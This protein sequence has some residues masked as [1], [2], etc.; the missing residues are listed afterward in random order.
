[1]YSKKPVLC[2]LHNHNTYYTSF[3]IIPVLLYLI[4][5]SHSYGVQDAMGFNTILLLLTVLL[6]PGDCH[7]VTPNSTAVAPA[8]TYSFAN[9]QAVVASL[10]IMRHQTIL[11]KRGESSLY[12]RG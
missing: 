11:K 5:S 2:F 3:G 6:D 12:F 10:Q 9:S 8:A 1:M 4:P 7:V